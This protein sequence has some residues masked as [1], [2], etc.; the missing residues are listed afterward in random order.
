MF[1]KNV[2]TGKCGPCSGI[3]YAYARGNTEGDFHPSGLVLERH[4][5]AT[6]RS[7]MGTSGAPGSRT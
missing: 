5:Q 2:P 7:H 4:I 1:Q 3:V 6:N